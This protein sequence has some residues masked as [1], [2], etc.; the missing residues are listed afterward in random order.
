MCLMNEGAIEVEFVPQARG[1][2]RNDGFVTDI[3]LGTPVEEGKPRV[4][5]DGRT[6]FWRCRCGPIS[7]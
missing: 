3:G 4:T 2:R 5:I 7:R 1:Q 6:A